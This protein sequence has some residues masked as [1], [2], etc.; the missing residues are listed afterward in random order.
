M[1]LIPE[2]V[3]TIKEAVAFFDPEALVYLFGSRVDPT[4]K[5]GDIDLLVMSQKLRPID[6]IQVLKKI[7]ETMEEQKMDLLIV[8]DGQDPFVQLILPNALQL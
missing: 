5:G 2:E 3:Q 7:F 8:A 4:K 6:S 1:R